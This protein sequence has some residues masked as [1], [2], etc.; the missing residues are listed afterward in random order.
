VPVNWSMIKLQCSS[1]AIS[2]SVTH[3]P[4]SC[5]ERLACT[6][7]GDGSLPH[8]RQRGCTFKDKWMKS[9]R[10]DCYNMEVDQGETITTTKAW[11]NNNEAPSVRTLSTQIPNLLH[12]KLMT[13]TGSQH[14]AQIEISYYWSKTFINDFAN[15]CV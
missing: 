5:V 8:A 6:T 15:F 7:H 1:N 2:I 13:P 9:K 4:S 3:S 11:L 10:H 14:Y 12:E